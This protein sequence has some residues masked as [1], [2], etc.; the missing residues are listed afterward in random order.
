[1]YISQEYI[2]TYIY[3]YTHTHTHNVSSQLLPICQWPHGNSCTWAHD[4]WL[5]TGRD[6]RCVGVILN[7]EIHFSFFRCHQ[8]FRFFYITFYQCVWIKHF[9]DCRQITS[10]TLNG[11]CLL[12][13]I[14]P[15][16]SCFL[17]LMDNIKMDTIA[18]KIKWKIHVLLT[19]YFKFWRY[20]L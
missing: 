9:R 12:S 20:F 15:P 18:T 4:V 3:I 10:V 11:F 13:K 14:P 19:L 2:Y 6:A 1:M 7:Q 5:I 16:A 8:I 17:M